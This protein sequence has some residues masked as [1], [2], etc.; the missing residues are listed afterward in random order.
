[1]PQ[2]LDASAP[3]FAARF[4]EFLSAKRDTEAAADQAA[5]ESGAAVRAEGDAA[6]FRYTERFDRFPIDADTVRIR[7]EEMAA[8]FA[9]TPGP[10]R[11][12]LELAVLAR[13]LL[14]AN[15]L[16]RAFDAWRCGVKSSKQARRRAAR[17]LKK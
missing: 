4:A 14:R 1:M 11:E 5:A 2:R 13:A 17:R 16:N 10:Q 8:A 6:V 12:A 9:A 15:K 3:D 7:P